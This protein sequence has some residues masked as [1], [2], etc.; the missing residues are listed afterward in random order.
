MRLDRYLKWSRVI[1]RR[2]MAKATCDAGRV[3]VNGAVA[4]PGKE[5]SVGDVVTVDLSRRVMKFRVLVVPARVPAKSEAGDL[6][7]VLEN[8]KKDPDA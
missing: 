7:D 3:R 4:R 6:I 8:R 2:P 5:L 1:P